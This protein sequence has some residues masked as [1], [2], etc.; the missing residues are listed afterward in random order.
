MIVVVPLIGYTFHSKHLIW[1]EIHHLQPFPTRIYGTLFSKI[2][3]VNNT[4]KI[5][6]SKSFFAV[7]FL[8]TITATVT[9]TAFLSM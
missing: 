6:Y 4:T 8:Q 9:S 7:N 5:G 3:P 1:S 2:S